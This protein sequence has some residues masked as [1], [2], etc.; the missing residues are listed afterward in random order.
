MKKYLITTGDED[1]IGFEVTAKALHEIGP[2]KNKGLYFFR[3]PNAKSCYLDLIDKKFKRV[4]FSNLTDA[5]NFHN[6]QQNTII[7]ISS[8]LNPAA[9]FKNAIQLCRDNNEFKGVVTGPLSKTLCSQI[10]GS[11]IGHTE[12]LAQEFKNLDLRMAF[13]G[14]NFNVL[15]HSH[16]IPLR[17]VS[18]ALNLVSLRVSIEMALQFRKQLNNNSSKP[19]GVLGLNPHSGENGLMGHEEEEYIN[20]IISKFS[21]QD[22]CGALVPDVAF[23]KKFWSKYSVY[24]ALYHDQ[25]LIPFKLIHGQ[26]RGIQVTL[27]LPFFR[28]S[29]DHGTAKEI[30]NLDQANCSSMLKALKWSLERDI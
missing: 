12:I 29:V 16:H 5:L 1:G 9:C 14:E 28:A 23:Q 2:Q 27:G 21:E 22:V 7:E 19:V 17:R 6:H 18:S 25:G 20:P 11:P 26:T 8:D 24:M 10:E 3:T 30:F 13:I 4:S 15:L